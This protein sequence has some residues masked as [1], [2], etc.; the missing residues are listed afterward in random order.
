[1]THNIYIG[2]IGLLNVRYSFFHESKVGHNLKTRAREN[3]IE[4]SYFADGGSGT[5][6][7][8]LNFDNGGRAVLRGNLLHKG[9]NASN[10]ILITHY[11]NIWGASY[12]SL[13][14]EHNTIVSTYSGGQF[15]DVN[16]GAPVTLTANIFA[17]TGNPSLLGGT[18]A[19]QTSNVI[20]SAA[21][22][23]GASNMATPNFWPAPS[24]L[25]QLN[26]PSSIVPAY[27]SDSPRPYMARAITGPTRLVGALQSTP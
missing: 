14:L 5:S 4:N 17:G 6:S 18:A 15:I 13:T 23:P 7:Y 3:V 27:T 16:T 12:N 19:T 22:I 21:Q 25:S 10:S 9:P 1:Y 20:T 11:A 24:L 2:R 8:L 26:L